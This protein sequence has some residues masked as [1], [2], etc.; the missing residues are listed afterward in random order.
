MLTIAFIAVFSILA[1][2]AAI[3]GAKHWHWFHV[4]VVAL[5]FFTT[6]GYAVLAAQAYRARTKFMK[7]ER[8]ARQQLEPLQELNAAIAR[9]TT[10]AA[11]IN[12]LRSRELAPKEAPIVEGADATRMVSLA[13]LKH[14]LSLAS[15][16]AGRVWRDAQ[17]QGAPNPQ[18]GQ[19]TVGIE[20]PVPLGIEVGA[21]LFA[22]E[23]G[24]ANTQ[25]PNQGRQ[26]VAEFRVTD[27]SG[28][29]VT[30]EP[31]LT[32]DPREAMRL[33]RSQ[34]P[35]SLYETM[36]GDSHALFAGMTDEELRQLMPAGSVEAYLRDGTPWTVD[37]GEE[38]K[39]GRD[40]EGNIVGIDDWDDTTRFVYRRQ[41]RDYAYLFNNLAKRRI[42]MI[43]TAQALKEDN[44]K[45][46]ATLA[47]ARKLGKQAQQ[48]QGKLKSDLA[49]VQNDLRAAE[50]HLA[51]VTRQ[52]D[53]GQRLL[54]LT[55]AANS[56]L[57][58]RLT[59]LQQQLAGGIDLETVPAPSRPALDRDAL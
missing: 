33:T 25:N 32:L 45:L 13:E 52:A 55:I 34:G 1:I 19:I 5:L 28:Q 50:A 30:L 58:G 49:G 22:F 56:E 57:A 26:Y 14:Q 8:D 51:G 3:F 36:P 16:R 48:E 17:P 29:Q 7:Q 42:E 12:R 59:M 53:R 6:L 41:L 40:E 44:A 35:W 11:V 54:A 15:R 46:Q 18:T 37:D 47:S 27:V 9:G 43:A 23:Q 10:N 31:S 4:T 24:P 20:Q 38:T 2:V 39:E 21:V